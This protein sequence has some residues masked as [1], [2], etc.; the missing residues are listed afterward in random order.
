[1]LGLCTKA[2]LGSGGNV[3][4]DMRVHSMRLLKSMGPGELQLYLY[5]K[6]LPIHS[7]TEE[8]RYPPPMDQFVVAN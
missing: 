2:N 6:I 4:S 7:M 3:A 1:M 5:P 8:V